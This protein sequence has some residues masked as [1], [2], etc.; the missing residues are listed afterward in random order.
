MTA[1]TDSTAARFRRLDGASLHPRQ[2]AHPRHPAGDCVDDLNFVL[3]WLGLITP[4]LRHSDDHREEESP[5]C[6]ALEMGVG[7]TQHRINA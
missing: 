6:D 1:S 2:R 5:R 7:L 3:A 4:L